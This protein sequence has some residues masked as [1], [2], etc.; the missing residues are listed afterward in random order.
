M[1]SKKIT[2]T[3]PWTVDFKMD[4]AARCLLCEKTDIPILVKCSAT[5]DVGICEPCA[6]I[7]HHL[8][9][10]APGEVPPQF[11][12]KAQK[13]IS[14]VYVLVPR[15]VAQTKRLGTDGKPDKPNPLWPVDYKFVVSTWDEDDTVDLPGVRVEPK[16][17]VADAAV[18][19]LGTVKL[20]TWPNFVTHLYTG[21]MPRG[22]LATV[23]LVSAW[24]H[25]DLKSH[26]DDLT[27]AEWPL[28]DHVTLMGGF[29][30]MVEAHWQS[31]LNYHYKEPIHTSEF[32]VQV[33]RSACEYIELRKALLEP[34]FILDAA[35]RL[36]VR[37]AE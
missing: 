26:K 6:V 28:S 10:Q 34:Y 33:K 25:E 12:E 19:A 17:S 5:D 35:F 3:P 22:R 1:L 24:Y 15:L 2:Y 20:A 29:Y 7:A 37:I 18:R 16:E 14:R 4:G 23:M 11:P 36:H 30:K 31:V 13:E 27:W 8:W 21:Y 9:R 32:A